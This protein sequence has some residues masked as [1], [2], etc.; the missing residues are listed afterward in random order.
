MQF[1]WLVAFT[2]ATIPAC[3]HAG[4]L[5]SAVA[6]YSNS[7]C[8]QPADVMTITS[9]SFCIPQNDHWDPVCENNEVSFSVSDCTRYFIGGWDEY[10]LLNEAFG[11]YDPYLLVEKYEG[12]CGNEY[13]LDNATAY[14]LNEECHKNQEGLTSSR[15]AI[16]STLVLTNYE[17][18]DCNAV[19]TETE[20]TWA[21]AT[22]N[23]C[24]DSNTRFNLRGQYPNLTMLAVYD[25]STCATKPVKVTFTQE[26]ACRAELDQGKN[27]CGLDGAGHYS[28]SSCYRDYF[29]F[30]NTAFGNYTPYLVVEGFADGY[31]NYLLNVTV[32]T[33]DGLCH[34]NVDAT[35]SFM[36]TVTTDGSAAITTYLDS[37]CG[38][39][40]NSTE[41]SERALL[42]YECVNDYRWN[43]GYSSSRR[44]SVGGM[45]DPLTNKKMSAVTMYENSLCSGPPAQIVVE[46]RLPCFVSETSWCENSMT[47]TNGVHQ[48]RSCVK[49][50]GSFGKSKFGT[51]PYV[52]VTEYAEGTECETLEGAVA[53]VADSRCHYSITD[54]TFFKI[55]L[56]FGNSLTI[57]T[58]PTSSCSDFDAEFV[59]IGLKYINTRACYQGYQTFYTNMTAVSTPKETPII[60]VDSMTREQIMFPE[61]LWD[62]APRRVFESD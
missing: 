46:S 4:V 51:T 5:H 45:G 14:L 39:V 15:L 53:Y 13:N 17:D 43:G 52:L 47:R 59:T 18:P 41:V 30:A 37:Y 3:I 23:Y 8:S 34:S 27:R 2:V 50:I 55:T 62:P 20:V 1:W 29:G 7:S 24:D 16:G 9:T 25:D 32:Y 6:V 58:Y 31:C 40:D 26:F 35:S 19:S 36:A 57:A 12:R 11:W 61:W 49:D 33:A 22:R 38:E 60:D 44:F 54:G 21:M 48:E 56:S 28:M 10:G 42:S